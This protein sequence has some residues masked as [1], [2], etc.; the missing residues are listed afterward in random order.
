MVAGPRKHLKRLTAPKSWMLSKLG[1]IFAPRPSPGPHKLRES[2]P[3]IVLL[4][5]RLK[6]ALTRRE[7]QIVVM[8]RLVKVDQKVRTDM[9]FPTGF[10]DVVSV[11]KTGENYRILYDVKG[12]FQMV[13]IKPEEAGYK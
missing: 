12:R 8:N 11:D 1:G 10:M 9:N 7:A 3:V 5:N 2:I 13:K 4:R 6:Y